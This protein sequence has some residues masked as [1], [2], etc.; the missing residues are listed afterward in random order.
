MKK[1]QVLF[2][3]MLLAGSLGMSG[4]L[5]AMEPGNPSPLSST[6]S[7]AGEG[8]SIWSR[9]WSYGSKAKDTISEWV[10][11]NPRTAVGV[12]LG[13]AA[14]WVVYRHFSANSI[15]EEEELEVAANTPEWQI[16]M[17]TMVEEVYKNNPKELEK[18]KKDAAKDP[19][20]VA[21]K[22]DF[23]RS[24]D[25]EQKRALL[26]ILQMYTAEY[27]QHA[28]EDIFNI[29]AKINNDY[30]DVANDL[31]TGM[32]FSTLVTRYSIRLTPQIITLFQQ[33]DKNLSSQR[34][35]QSSFKRQN[36]L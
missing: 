26:D 11:E 16:I 4:S 35:F 34:N 20:L 22:A 1:L 17:Y 2:S 36:S 14:L 31:V 3:I 9:M 27:Q 18:A 8:T 28:L 13:A 7:E 23:Q 12:G 10:S 5:V 24:L 32:S 33:Y 21:K 29:L 6:A 25:K 15:N 19:Y 30:N